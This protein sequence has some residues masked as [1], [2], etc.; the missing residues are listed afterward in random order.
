MQK[1]KWP[2]HTFIQFIIMCLPLVNKKGD[3]VTRTSIIV[4]RANI[5][6]VTAVT[7]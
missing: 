6:W 7:I 4:E 1:G 2:E 5:S 3:A